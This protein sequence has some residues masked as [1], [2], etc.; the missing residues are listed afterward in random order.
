MMNLTEISTAH[1]A[2]LQ[3]LHQIEVS[4][5]EFTSF[6]HNAMDRLNCAFSAPSTAIDDPI[7][8]Q[9]CPPAGNKRW[10]FQSPAGLKPHKFCTCQLT[11]SVFI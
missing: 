4:D 2:D 11:A 5:A 6:N 7:H 1:T 10:F 9:A 3:S 8:Q